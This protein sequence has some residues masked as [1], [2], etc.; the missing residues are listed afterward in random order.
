[1]AIEV[2][3]NEVV[4]FSL[5]GFSTG[6]ALLANLLEFA[7]GERGLAEKFA[8]EA[9]RVGEI[10][11]EGADAGAGLI[12]AAV[13]ADLRFELVG[14]ILNLLTV[15][16]FCAA[17]QERAGDTGRGVFALQGFSVAEMEVDASHNGAAASLLGE[18]NELHAV[19]Q[20][21]ANNAGLDVLRSGI[22]GLALRDG[23][24]ALVILED[25]GGIR[26]GG[27]F[28]AV[29]RSGRQEFTH[30]A[31]RGFEVGLGDTGHV[32]GR[33]LHDFVTIEE[34][35]APV[36]LPHCAAK[37]N[38]DGLRI[39]EGQLNVFEDAALG[40][41]DFL[42]R[43]RIGGE[44]FHNFDESLLSIV[45]GLVGLELCKGL[46]DARI[47]HAV[48]AHVGGDCLLGIDEFLVEA[49]CLRGA[50]N[51]RG[52]LKGCCVGVKAGRDMVNGDDRLDVSDATENDGALAL[53]GRL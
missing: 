13:D 9:K 10:G 3:L 39:R 41:I 31:I 16:V 23:S 35:D 36:A 33:D 40:P 25:I 29:G 19:G 6:D 15:L 14:F 34:Q 24:A 38:G 5:A 8:H 28:G 53:L 27:Y 20:L 50:E 21:G 52:N 18:H 51:L 2:D 17:H 44:A 48:G 7:F 49:A 22:K 1:M 46:S 26:R 12:D 32:G 11:I 47:V 43:G 45:D 4:G 42:L 37:N 30:G